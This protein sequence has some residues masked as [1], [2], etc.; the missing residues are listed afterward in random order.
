[1]ADKGL[2]PDALEDISDNVPDWGAPGWLQENSGTLKAFLKDPRGYVIGLFLSWLVTNLILR[3]AGWTF[4]FLDWGVSTA[5]EGIETSVRAGLGNAGEGIWMATIGTPTEPGF[6]YSLQQALA[7]II[8]SLGVGAPIATVA[9][10]FVIA[11]VVMTI[12]YYVVRI[13]FDAIPGG[14]AFL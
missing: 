14:G 2:S 10:Q 9:S 3:P 5:L 13:I 8:G 11:M 1:M 4:A 6:F 12:A 7:G